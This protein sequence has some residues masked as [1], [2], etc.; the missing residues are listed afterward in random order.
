MGIVI[1]LIII[2]II[3]LSTFLAYKKGLIKLAVQLCSFI[4]AIIVTVILQE[5][6]KH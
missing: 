1:D 4:I 5:S 2:G 6:M 3:L